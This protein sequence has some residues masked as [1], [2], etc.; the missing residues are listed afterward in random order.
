MVVER[1][2]EIAKTEGPHSRPPFA[3]PLI[4]QNHLLPLLVVPVSLVYVCCV[5]ES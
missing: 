4:N 2:I 5:R 1:E 3:I